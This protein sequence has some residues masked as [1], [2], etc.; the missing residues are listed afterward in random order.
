MNYEIPYTCISH[1]G[2]C[3]PNNQDNFICGERCRELEEIEFLCRP[4]EERQ[5]GPPAAE[6]FVVTGRLTSG[7]PSMLGIFD[8]LGGE[9]CGEIAALLAAR[10]ASEASLSGDPE[11]DLLALCRRANARICRFAEQNGVLSTGTTAA[12]LEF[13]PD[14]IGLCNI[15]DSKIF[16]FSEEGMEQLSEDHVCAVPYGT[17]PPLSQCLGI[18]PSEMVIAPYTVKFP[19]RAGDV[20]LICS[21]GL[22]DM[23]EQGEIAQI[24]GAFGPESAGDRLLARALENGGRDNIT[25]LLCGIV[26][27]S[28][29]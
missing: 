16:R 5:E 3:R 25:I 18:P 24:L 20:Y 4:E 1:T 28:I 11:E 10:E 12:L 2:L 26:P 29:E 13:E 22:T 19:Y 15:G 17:K 9:E 23:V 7:R 8:G 21:D 6:P 14:C 27:K